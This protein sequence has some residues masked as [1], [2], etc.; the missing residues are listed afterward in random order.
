MARVPV[1][2][3]T[4]DE[5]VWLSENRCKHGHPYLSHYNCY[6]D[7]AGR[8][9]KIGFLDIES[10]NLNSDFGYIFSYCIKE[11]GGE[12]LGRAVTTREIRGGVYDKKLMQECVKDIR[13]FDRIVTYYG[14][15]FDLPALRTRCLYWGISFPKYKELVHTDVYPIVKNRLNLHRNRL[16]T[17]CNFLDIPSK[18]HRLEPDIWFAAMGGDKKALEY[19]LEHNKEDVISLEL[20]W[21]RLKEYARTPQVSV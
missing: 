11:K 8:E 3:M 15:K 9:E 13:K 7:E 17:A 4:K 5:I 18:E 14:T 16:E 2:R 6:L 20:L 1:R 21:T 19:I 12:I 10:T